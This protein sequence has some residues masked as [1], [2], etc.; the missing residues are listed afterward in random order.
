[1]AFAE[2]RKCELLLPIDIVVAEQAQPGRRPAVRELGEIDPHERILDAGP[3]TVARLC[4]AMDEAKTLIWNGPLGVFEVPPFDKGDHGGGTPRRGAGQGRA[5]WWRWPAAV[6]R[7]RRSTRP[8][9]RAT[10]PSSR[11][12]AA[13]FLNGWKA[14]P[15]L[16]S[17]R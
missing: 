11:P 6:I 10:S 17:K 13:R 3:E 5:S 9:V 4:K 16:A 14:R 12:P 15:F 7:W 2:S 8:G 1:M